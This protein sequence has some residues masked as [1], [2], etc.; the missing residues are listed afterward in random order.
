MSEVL[1]WP[2]AVAWIVDILDEM[3]NAIGTVD[4]SIDRDEAQ[5][6][7]PF[8]ELDAAREKLEKLRRLLVLRAVDSAVGTITMKDECPHC[9]ARTMYPWGT[10]PMATARVCPQCGCTE[11]R[12]VATAESAPAPDQPVDVDRSTA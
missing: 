3:C 5:A 6:G 2:D 11:I 8:D 7:R 12:K 9:G 10:P 4:S 1:Q